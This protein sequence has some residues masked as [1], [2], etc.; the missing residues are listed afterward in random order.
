MLKEELQENENPVSGL[1]RVPAALLLDNPEVQQAFLA[2]RAE[3]FGCKSPSST[4]S[5]GALAPLGRS[6]AAAE[7]VSSLFA[8][9]DYD[10]REGLSA[11]LQATGASTVIFGS[12]RRIFCL[13]GGLCRGLTASALAFQRRRRAP[14]F[15]GAPGQLEDSYELQPVALEQESS[16]GRQPSGGLMLPRKV[17]R[18]A[19][20]RLRFSYASEYR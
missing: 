1:Q 18:R 16:G 2:V 20:G 4:S 8:G 17:R 12:G 5:K 10:G 13:P 11:F 14:G 9:F 6:A 19:G 3:S 7:V 15:V